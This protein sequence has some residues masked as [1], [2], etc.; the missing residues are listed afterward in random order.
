MKKIVWFTGASGFIGKNFINNFDAT[1]YDLVVFARESSVVINQTKN[2]IKILRVNFEDVDDLKVKFDLLKAQDRKPDFVV[3]NLGLTQALRSSKYFDVNVGLSKN[4]FNTL[5]SCDLK[6]EKIIYI[7]SL[8]AVGPVAFEEKIDESTAPKPV[9]FYGESKLEAEKYLLQSFSNLII[10]RPTAVYGKFDFNTLK[11]F[12]A[13][14]SGFEIYFG[15]KKQ[16]LSFIH[17]D[18]LV[19]AIFN[20]IESRTDS[21][22]FNISDGH[23]YCIEDYYSAIKFA[24]GKNTFRI[25]LPK[26]TL[27]MAGVIS[28]IISLVQGKTSILTLDKTN[29]LLAQSWCCDIAEAT[30]KI[31]F[32]PK[33]TLTEGLNSSVNWFKDNGY[34]K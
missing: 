15:N 20:S 4:F 7:S 9:T 18:D 16:V 6:P 19:R 1:K 21:G 33:I 17:V 5:L 2:P 30:R 3:Y 8:A 26:F 14:N 28:E 25:V 24:L 34:L 27:R 31:G 11:I 12:R 10:L 13:I 22:I 32:S 29:E 23:C